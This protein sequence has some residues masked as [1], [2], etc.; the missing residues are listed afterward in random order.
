MPS[1]SK[2]ITLERPPRRT[3]TA[4]QNHYPQT[5]LR[6]PGNR[7][8]TVEAAPDHNGVETAAQVHRQSP[9][10]CRGPVLH[11]SRDSVRIVRLMKD[12]IYLMASWPRARVRWTAMAMCRYPSVS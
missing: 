5:R 7:H 11:L 2:I 4:L 10:T 12:R 9:P 8:R 3:P 6:Q 1:T